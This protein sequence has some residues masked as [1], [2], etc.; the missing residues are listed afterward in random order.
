MKLRVTITLIGD[1]TYIDDKDKA[2]NVS[3]SQILDD[4]GEQIQEDI[5]AV[6]PEEFY[7]QNE[8]G[9][10]VVLSVEVD[11]VVVR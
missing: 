10:D 9:Y 11:E 5:L 3:K 2:R 1:A 4:M 7:F 8:D 6:I